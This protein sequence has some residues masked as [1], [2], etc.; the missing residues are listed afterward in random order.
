MKVRVVARL[1]SA[2]RMVALRTLRQWLHLPRVVARRACVVAEMSRVHPPHELVATL[3]LTWADKATAQAQA[4][5]IVR[6]LARV[7][8]LMGAG[9][10]TATYVT[11]AD[12]HPPWWPRP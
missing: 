10:L 7:G 6:E 1:L 5:I 12:D 2:R 4:D 8:M 11:E 3:A 9:V